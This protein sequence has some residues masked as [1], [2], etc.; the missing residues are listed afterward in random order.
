[1]E[2]TNFSP[3][4]INSINLARSIAVENNH[5]YLTTEHL[6]KAFLSD[7]DELI[8]KLINIAGGQASHTDAMVAKL[9]S[10]MPQN[11][12]DKNK[13]YLTDSLDK[14]L[15]LATLLSE[16]AGD[17]LLSI[18][19]VLLAITRDEN[20]KKL[21]NVTSESFENAINAFKMG[22]T[23]A[24]DNLLDSEK[25]EAIN[26]YTS[27]LTA[28]AA[29]GSLDPMIGREAEVKKM[30]QILS[31]RSKNNPVL[32]GESGVGKTAIA[33]G[34][35]MRIINNDVPDSLKNKRLLALD[36][37]A[38]VAGAS[39]RG[40]LEERVK[41]ILKEIKEI[42]SVIL[43]IDE[44]HTLVNAGKSDGGTDISGMLK[45]ALAEGYL[46]CLG[47]STLEGYSRNISINFC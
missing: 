33:N 43:F 27:D 23:K 36:L 21:I 12:T 10:K 31:R 6:V 30:I 41:A 2:T 13:V 17:K 46:H 44:L 42:G 4:V 45:P 16:T 29:N 47:A 19:Y 15:N 26:Q 3:N 24:D 32:I 35:A 40:Q 9:L 8:V 38:L 25:Y 7:K 28:K 18:E 37:G 5:E 22:R 39:Y 14:I 20:A 1:M 34:L 11:A